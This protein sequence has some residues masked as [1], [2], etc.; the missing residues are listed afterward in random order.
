MSIEKLAK[1]VV[2]YLQTDAAIDSVRRYVGLEPNLKA[3]PGILFDQIQPVFETRMNHGITRDDLLALVFLSVTPSPS[4]TLKQITP[5]FQ[6]NFKNLLFQIP[7]S[8]GLFNM[9]RKIVLSQLKELT[10]LEDQ[11]CEVDGVDRVISS[12]LIAHIWPSLWP[13]R[14]QV[15]MCSLGL[16]HPG[17]AMYVRTILLHDDQA[18]L[19]TIQNWQ[20]EI[21]ELATL[22]ALRLFDIVIWMHHR[23][24]H[25]NSTPCKDREHWS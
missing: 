20:S 10:A 13:M 4:L 19:S 15:V 24:D 1:R 17:F 2:Q 11:L 18:G 3:N 14:D 25:F 9:D 12:K 22:S 21:P 7:T 16:N 5:E 6:Q 8:T 23:D